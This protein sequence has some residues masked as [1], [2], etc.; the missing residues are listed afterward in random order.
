[1]DNFMWPA[2]QCVRLIYFTLPQTKH[3]IYKKK[4]GVKRIGP[5]HDTLIKF[6]HDCN[7]HGDELIS[8]WQV[9]IA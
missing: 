5:Y 2:V 9:I 4:S 1:M 3:V 7:H 8:F 6:N